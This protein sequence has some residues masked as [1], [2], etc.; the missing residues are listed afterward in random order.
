MKIIIMPKDRIGEAVAD[1]VEAILAVKPDAVLGMTT[2]NTPLAAGVYDELVRRENDGRLT[3]ASS[4]FVNP[5]E[6]IGIGPDNEHSYYQYMKRHLLD[7]IR[8]QPKEWIIPIGTAEDPQSECDRLEKSIGELGGVD[9]QLLGIGINGHICFIEPA[10]SLPSRCFITPI[11]EVNRELYAREYGSLDAVPTTAITY[12]IRTVLSAR[13]LCLIVNGR[14]KAGILAQALTGGVSTE[15]PASV[16]Q[17]HPDVTV[18][19][20]PDAAAELDE[21]ELRRRGA[22]VVRL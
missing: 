8:S 5:D 15:L 10:R 21:N 18:L 1:R 16:L 3:F 2:G 17:L 11:A 20:D 9:W 14:H 12:G 13:E 22:E 19:L 4:A 7:H 6:Q